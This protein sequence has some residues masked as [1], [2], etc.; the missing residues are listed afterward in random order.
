MA[1]RFLIVGEGSYKY[2]FSKVWNHL[3]KMVNG[4]IKINGKFD[5]AWHFSILSKYLPRKY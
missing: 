1:A 5:E 3:I 2:A 4:L